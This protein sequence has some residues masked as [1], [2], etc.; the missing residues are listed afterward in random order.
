MQSRKM[1]K[2]TLPKTT[3]SRRDVLRTFIAAPALLP[4]IAAG[5]SVAQASTGPD[6]TLAAATMGLISATVCSLMPETTEGPYYIDPKLVRQDITEGRKGI[7]L[8]MQIQVVTADCR[9]VKDAR[10]DIW[11]CD[12]E[13][14]YSGYANMGSKRDNDT[15]GQTFLRGTQTTDANGIVTFDTIYP[16]WYSGRTAHVHYKIFL[17]E[18]TV[19]TSQIFFPDALNEYIYL[20]SPEYKRSAERDTVN[21]IDGIAAQAGEGSYCAIREQKDRYS[22]A[23]VVGID[24]AAEWKEQNQGMNGA[25]PGAPGGKSGEGRPAPGQMPAGANGAPPSGPPPEGFGGAGGPP[26]RRD[27]N[28]RMFPGA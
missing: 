9:P 20:K 1:N 27:D 11:Q 10:V 24:P 2:T 8:R 16:G 12:A 17:N 23:L 15:T 25:P 3:S 4:V 21:S 19:L 6:L 7:P 14:N 18:K 13:G 22:A 5:S 28:T 26:S